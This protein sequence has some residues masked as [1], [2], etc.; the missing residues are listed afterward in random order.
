MVAAFR[1]EGATGATP[2]L[3]VMVSVI[4]G[5]IYIIASVSRVAGEL[6]LVISIVITSGLSRSASTHFRYEFV[7]ASKSRDGFEIMMVIMFTPNICKPTT[8]RFGLNSCLVNG[9]RS[10][11]SKVQAVFKFSLVRAAERNL[12]TC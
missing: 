7:E 9:T 11:K 10:Q 1:V 5:I 3:D 4:G 8:K 12:T 6:M 2:R